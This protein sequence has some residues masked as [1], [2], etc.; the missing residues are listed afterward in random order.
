MRADIHVQVPRACREFEELGF[1]TFH[2][3]VMQ[4]CRRWLLI[5]VRQAV[6]KASGCIRIQAGKGRCLWNATIGTGIWVCLEWVYSSQPKTWSAAHRAVCWPDSFPAAVLFRQPKTG[7]NKWCL[8]RIRA[9][10]GTSRCINCVLLYRACFCKKN[11]H[12]HAYTSLDHSGPASHRQE[13]SE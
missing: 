13:W 5:I 4:A 6:P 2:K 11:M 7:S 3:S 1:R 10:Q 9:H 12:M 8:R